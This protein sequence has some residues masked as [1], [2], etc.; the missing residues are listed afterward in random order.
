MVSFLRL[1]SQEA[2]EKRAMSKHIIKLVSCVRR[3]KPIERPQ[4]EETT[5]DCNVKHEEKRRRGK[6]V[7]KVLARIVSIR[8]TKSKGK[9]RGLSELRPDTEVGRRNEVAFRTPDS[10]PRESIGRVIMPRPRSVSFN[11]MV[12]V[13]HGA[14]SMLVSQGSLVVIFVS[15]NTSPRTVV[16]VVLYV[17]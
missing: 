7:R 6:A 16:K 1:P 11:D 5:D 13:G 3:A 14:R 4:D 17:G 9:D 2:R 10:T 12:K 15:N 8:V